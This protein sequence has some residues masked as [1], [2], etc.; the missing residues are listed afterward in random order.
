MNL[1][2]EKL[3]HEVETLP[4]SMQQEVLH[5]VEFLKL[6]ARQTVEI[7]GNEAEPNGAKIARLME[8]IAARGTAFSDIKDPAVNGQQN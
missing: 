6:K 7:V 1:Q 2:T 4:P 5:F 8:Q 3:L